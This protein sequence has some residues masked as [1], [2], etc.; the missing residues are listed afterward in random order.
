M[1]SP[2]NRFSTYGQSDIGLMREQNEDNFFIDD[3]RHVFAVA[4]GLG[5]LPQGS[6]ASEIAVK[7]L[8]DY[9]NSVKTDKQLVL[10]DVFKRINKSV[11]LKGRTVS[12][13]M[14][15][16]T[17]LTVAQLENDALKIGHIGD[18]AIVL[19]RE[20]SWKQLTRDH[21]MAQ[22]MLDRLRPG[23]QAYIPDYYSHTLTKCIGQ[24]AE[25]DAD[26]F[27]HPVDPKDRILIFSDGVTKTME[28]DELHDRIFAADDPQTFVQ[29]IIKTANE[30]GGPDNVTAVAVFLD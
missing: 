9:L 20:G 23:E 22:D 30:R 14:G 12:E 2:N 3:Y 26:I 27:E 28:L 21:T 4:D 10:A 5:G 18:S 25:V 8:S 6:L 16:G 1:S 17:T 13:E 29:E 7:E 15:I 19:F 11:F 24:I